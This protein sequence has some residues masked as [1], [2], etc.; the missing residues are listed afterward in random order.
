MKRRIVAGTNGINVFFFMIFVT[1]R[2]TISK[3][4]LPTSSYIHTCVMDLA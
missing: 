4:N 1:A 2:S 3:F